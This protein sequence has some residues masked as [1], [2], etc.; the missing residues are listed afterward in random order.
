MSEAIIARGG[1][2]IGQQADLSGINASLSAINSGMLSI[3]T[4]IN[5][6]N[7]NLGSLWDTVNDIGNG[8]LDTATNTIIATN[9]YYNCTKSG[10]YKVSVCGGG[11]GAYL[12]IAANRATS[13]GSGYINTRTIHLNKGDSIYVTIGQGGT[14]STE[15]QGTRNGGSTFFGTYLSAN[16]GT[17]G[18]YS[19]GG[20]GGNSGTSITISDIVEPTT[21]VNG[22]R[23]YISNNS[24]TT[25]GSNRSYYGDGGDIVYYRYSQSSSSYNNGNSGCCIVTYIN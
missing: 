8:A 18:S 22:G 21:Y 10:N 9:G 7:S 25:T 5:Q 12:W 1:K 20:T 23:L 19:V 15:Y 13:G 16:G 4:R 14:K 3:N 17:S 6:I 11:G 24:F 2:G